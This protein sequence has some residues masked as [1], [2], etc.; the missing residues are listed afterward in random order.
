MHRIFRRALNG[1][2]GESKPIISVIIDVRNFSS[3]S[4]K[5]DSVDVAAFIRKV[6]MKIIDEYFPFASFYKS[7]GDGLLLTIPW[8]EG[9]L[10]EMSQEV[11]E[12]CIKC[13]SEFGDICSGDPA[14]NFSVPDKIGIGVSRGSAC[15]LAS[16]RKTIDYAG[17]LLNLTARLTDLA[18]PSGIVIDSAF[19]LDLLSE[20]QQKIFKEEKVFLKGIAEKESVPIYFTP[21]FTAIPEYN[22]HL[23][24]GEK[25]RHQVDVKPF[26]DLLKLGRFQYNL[27][28]V[29][30]SEKSIKV[31]VIRDKIINGT[32]SKQYS[33]YHRFSGFEYF[34]DGGE[35]IVVVDFPKLCEVLKK[36]QVKEDM[37]ITV[38]ITYIEK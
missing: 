32:V 5:C 7:T 25:W 17:R 34:F 13:H 2:T 20:D 24:K 26:K 30:E 9:T 28:S 29:P 3:F 33:T 15:R 16:G 22:K 10:E 18:R 35:P 19:V 12:S 8:N 4:Q 38:E 36:N 1:A 27:E 14:T 31:K 6:Y 11:I 23:I 37:D 21:E